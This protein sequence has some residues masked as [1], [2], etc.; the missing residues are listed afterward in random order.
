M[1]LRSGQNSFPF[2]RLFGTAIA[3]LPV[4]ANAGA[5]IFADEDDPYI[6]THPSGYTAAGGVLDI[7]VCIDDSAVDATEME[8]PI[9]NIM[10]EINGMA[11]S[12]PNLFFGGGTNIPPG[13]LDFES[14]GL[15]EL[16]HCIGLDHPNLGA[17]PGVTG[18]DKEFTASGDGP[19]DAFSF[20][21][22]D[23]GVIGS[24]D[25][26]R[27]DDQNLHWFE[28]GVNN[29]FLETTTP[30]AITYSRD[31]DDLPMSHEYPANADRVV[32]MFLGFTDTEAVMQ[33]GQGTDEE[34]RLLQADDVTTLR[35]GMTGF[36]E[37]ASTTDDYTIHM[38]YG[39]IRAD[40]SECDIVVESET[41]GFGVCSVGLS[42]S[43]GGGIHW[44][45]TSATFKYN[46]N[47][48]W[49]FNPVLNT[50]CSADDDTLSFSSVTHSAT[51]IHEACTSITY[52]PA[53]VISASGVVTATAP[54]ITLGP[55]TTIEGIFTAF[56]AIP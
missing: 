45:I 6:I 25:D 30:E 16:V 2:L 32:G 48:P 26:V 12:T 37:I 42:T 27:D 29:P 22:G 53:Y 28:K 47:L 35:M 33:Q 50:D 46:S 41:G 8:I 20:D 44:W 5:Y 51:H 56:S 3:L 1:S 13:E 39:G 43:G 10:K 23:D 52:G 40:T 15:H 4:F 54:T 34:Q 7:V 17:Q 9:R 21:D 36:D 19:N 55:G 11:A 24:S 14:L 38:V 49:F 18:S 31:V